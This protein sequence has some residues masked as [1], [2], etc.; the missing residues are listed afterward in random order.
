[1]IKKILS[2]TFA[3]LTAFTMLT[4]CNNNSTVGGEYAKR[5]KKVVLS[6]VEAGYGRTHY[7][8]MA[9]DFMDNYNDEIYLELKT[10]TN[11]GNIRALIETG[12]MEGD[13][14]QVPVD[15]YGYSHCLEEL[16]PLFEKTP[17]NESV[18]IKDKNPELY[19]YY[20]ENNGIYQ[21]S[22][23]VNTYVFAYNKT[24]LDKAFETE[25]SYIL[26][27][28]TDEFFA[29]G[30]VLA[31]KGVY[32]TSAAISDAG[33]GD[34]L[35]YLYP[36]WFAQLQG[37]EGYEKFFKGEIYDATSNEWKLD[38]TGETRIISDNKQQIID[39]YEI[40][41][42]LLSE[43]N[44][45]LHSVSREF[46]YLDNDMV[47]A[48]GGYGSNRQ[49][50]GFL[51]IGP[52]YETEIMPLIEDGMV[53]DG[54]DY[55]AMRVPVASAI[56]KYLEYRSAGAYMTDKMLSEVIKTIDEGGTS[57]AGVSEKDF[58]KIKEARKMNAQ[59]ICSE[60]VVPKLS[61]ESK[62]ADVF[63]V[64]EYLASDR[65]Q[66][67]CANALGGLSLM[68]FGNEP[69][70]FDV[71]PTSFIKEYNQIYH[72]KDNVTVDYA[73]L[74]TLQSKHLK[75]KYYYIPGGSRMSAYIYTNSNPQTA[76]EM[77]NSL[78]NNVKDVWADYV[79]NYNIA[80]GVSQ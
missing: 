74:N 45:Y 54:Q 18:K 20:M 8:A 58:N 37:K 21:M 2:I 64:L 75:H 4:G 12:E 80:L 73:R 32:L 36:V 26:P 67:A 10:Y 63:E 5:E 17:K 27:R 23:G 65:A 68:A 56:V 62:K 46:D 11:T 76:T 79:K 48:G 69:G 9:K 24:T 19:N 43:K 53:D 15:M 16:S 77:Y 31:D 59:I 40:C 47:F 60:F 49:K 22:E 33:G 55:G 42:T 52:W 28:T 57:F 70:S 39:T 13:I 66:K 61:D 51:Y 14:I 71:T 25:G 41:N 34:Y 72:D 30:D 3:T 1:M 7:E 6:Y 50:T 78:F 35:E 29:F 38:E 44:G